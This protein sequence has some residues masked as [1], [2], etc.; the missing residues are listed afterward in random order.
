[1]TVSIIIV[2]YNSSPLLIECVAAALAA[3][4]PVRVI[5]AD[6]GSTDCT[7]E[8]LEEWART[9][10][11]L[12]VLRNGANLG[13]ARGN[14]RA[15]ELAE[16]EFVLFLNPDCL[17]PADALARLLA[18]L[19]EHPEAGMAGCLIRNADGSEEPAGRRAIPDP[20]GLLRR[21]LGRRPPAASPLPTAPTPVAAISGAFMLVRRAAL[22][23]VGSFDPGYFMHWEDL[24]LCLRF[25]RAGY[26]ILFVPD[27]EVRH[28][29]GRSSRRTPISVEWHKHRGMLRFFRKFYFRGWRLPL[30]APVAAAV[31]L[32][33]ALRI[34]RRPG[35]EAAPMA[36]EAAF[37]ETAA[38]AT[39]VWVFGATSLVGRCLLPRLVAAG[40][41]V[42]AF[43]SA[44]A[45]AH[46]QS[47]RLI[48]QQARLDRA[49]HPLPGTPAILLHLAPLPLLPPWIDL[50]A[51][52]GVK[53][54][55][56][57]G[58]TSRITKRTS[59]DPAERALA[60]ALATAETATA[61]ACERH[62]IAWAIFRPTMIY[63]LGHERNVTLLARFIRRFRFFPMPGAGSGLRQP[64]HADDL[65]C[66]CLALLER[67]SGWN[68]GYDLSGGETL[69]Y[70]AMVEAIFR[71]CALPPRIVRPPAWIWAAGLFALRRL[72]GYRTVN[73][74]M[75][76]RVDT[77]LCFDHRAATEGFG[78]APRPFRP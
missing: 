42:R 30:L 44:P 18:V 72:P 60:A 70:R 7:I 76:E 17:L 20:G 63:C 24:D 6:N 65:A 54:M 48:W 67:D 10:P 64:V 62:G 50:L 53:R 33:F 37:D 45:A 28:F 4:V 49:P 25:R 43:G 75:L 57:F 52:A 11:R 8:P 2:S 34:C 47:P 77:D 73:R 46:D 13:F 69:S 19:A 38:A 9:E 40:Y 58:S 39:E 41:R 21:A 68:A 66:A 51:E 78:Y 3:T 26:S 15:L 12:R 36:D 74:Q 23:H 59:A 14:A 31:G 61:A 55:I 35:G 29:K 1:M 5:V 32:R 22:A 16:G 27:V 56:A 71:R